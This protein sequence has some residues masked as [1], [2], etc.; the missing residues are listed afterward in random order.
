MSRAL[1]S[2]FKGWSAVYTQLP[3]VRVLAVCLGT[4]A[5]RCSLCSARALQRLG[6]HSLPQ[7]VCRERERELGG[8]P[9]CL[10]TPLP[11]LWGQAQSWHPFEMRTWS[12]L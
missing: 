9:P 11:S 5:A 1:G 12:Q 6:G 3:L 7:E 4:L 2:G 8:S 10:V